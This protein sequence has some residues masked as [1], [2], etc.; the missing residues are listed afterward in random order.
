MLHVPS[1]LIGSFPQCLLET[2]RGHCELY[3]VSIQITRKYCVFFMIHTPHTNPTGTFGNSEENF[4]M[5]RVFKMLQ[6]REKILSKR[7]HS[8]QQDQQHT[9]NYRGKIWSKSLKIMNSTHSKLSCLRHQSETPQSDA[10]SSTVAQ[11]LWLTNPNTHRE[12]EPNFVNW[13]LVGCMLQKEMPHSLSSEEALFHL[14]GY[15]NYHTMVLSSEYMEDN[16]GRCTVCYRCKED[17]WDSFYWNY[18]LLS[19]CLH[20]IWRPFMNTYTTRE[21]TTSLFSKRVQ[22]LHCKEFLVWIVS[23]RFVASYFDRPEKECRFYRWSK[24][25][26]GMW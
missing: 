11:D 17:C 3:V 20:T 9:R 18:E 13:N 16:G 19:T 22:K 21:G 4:L 15:V 1:T 12:V 7:I 23:R 6:I 2:L 25:Q 24:L 10:I 8:R 14:S 5:L 26:N